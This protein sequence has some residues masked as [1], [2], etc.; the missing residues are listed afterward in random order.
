[1][2]RLPFIASKSVKLIVAS[3]FLMLTM[4]VQ[5]R[6]NPIAVYPPEF[7]VSELKFDSS[8]EWVIELKSIH[9][10]IP[11]D[12]DSIR[13]STSSGSAKWKNP[14]LSDTE[15]TIFILRNDSLDSD[16]VIHQEG[17]FV[18]ITTFYNEGYYGESI[19][20]T[21]TFGNYQGATVRS[22]KGEESIAYVADYRMDYN[23]DDFFKSRSVPIY[24]NLYTIATGYPNESNVCVGKIKAKIHN[25]NNQPFSESKLQLRDEHYTNVF[26]MEQQED[27]TYLGNLYACYYYFDKLHPWI[28][29][30]TGYYN[31]S[32]RRDYWTIEPIQFEGEQDTVISLDICINSY[33]DI[34]TVKKEE[35]HV[36]K[37]YPNPIIENSFY[38]ETALP[39]KSTNSVIEIIGLNGQKIGYYPVSES[40]GNIKL[41]SNIL[42][43][44]YTVCL[45]VNNKNYIAVKI[46]VP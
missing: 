9:F 3:V 39:V 40:K 8:G 30:F 29:P 36:L 4:N 32:Y 10:D 46:M 20:H 2:K 24:S 45:I 11:E 16:L 14:M 44:I 13:I 41:P 22:P 34:Q 43:G 31:N 35:D 5:L 17:D 19:T 25:P 28:D 27:G 42:H 33:M 23:H 7:F 15:D 18:Q 21:L 37:I 38:Y 12:V 6:A 26:D 1:M